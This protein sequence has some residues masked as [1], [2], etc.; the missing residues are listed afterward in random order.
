MVWGCFY[1]GG[2]GPL[3]TLHGSVDQDKYVQ[4]L[5]DK[6][7]PYLHKLTN[8]HGHDLIF[9][10]DGA[11]SHTGGYA[12]WWKNK[13]CIKGFDF[14]PAQTPDLNPTENLW[15]ALG[16]RIGKRRH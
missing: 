7:L 2:L 10:E 13:A 9:Q 14:W 5:S 11:S 12:R 15:Y 3:V 6:F 4:C 16:K 1:T 8:E